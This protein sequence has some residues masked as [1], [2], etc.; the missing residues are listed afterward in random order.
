MLAAPYVLAYGAAWTQWSGGNGPSCTSCQGAHLRLLW[1]LCCES[2]AGHCAMAV[3]CSSVMSGSHDPF[4]PDLLPGHGYTL[5]TVD[6]DAFDRSHPVAR[7]IIHWIVSNIPGCI[8]PTQ[9]TLKLRFWFEVLFSCTVPA[10]L[11]Y[12]AF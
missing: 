9:G 12:F 4:G 2:A 1:P 6:P 8:L 3:C 7:N 5:V 10:V 11:G